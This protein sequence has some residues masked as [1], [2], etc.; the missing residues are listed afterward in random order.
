MFHN[1]RHSRVFLFIIFLAP[2]RQEEESV[3]LFTK[4]R[5]SEAMSRIQPGNTHVTMTLLSK[6]AIAFAFL[7]RLAG[8]GPRWPRS[9]VTSRVNGFQ[10]LRNQS[11]GWYAR[12][13]SSDVANRS[14]VSLLAEP[15]L[16][17][18]F[19]SR[20]TIAEKQCR[21]F[22]LLRNNGAPFGRAALGRG[23]RRRVPRRIVC[24]RQ[25]CGVGSE[26]YDVDLRW[27]VSDVDLRWCE[28]SDVD[29][30]WCEI[31]DVDLRWCVVQSPSQRW[32]WPRTKTQGAAP[33]FCANLLSTPGL[34]SR[35]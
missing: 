8:H 16:P 34:R 19:D 6:T 25:G 5:T 31:S 10:R 13:R 22:S 3:S 9:H 12:S 33:D 2:E 26:I 27:C 28:I 29:L 18:P 1:K 4:E 24:P 7:A 20:A 32:A 15:S 23:Q 11:Q 14:L 30:R 17:F 35:R 21:A